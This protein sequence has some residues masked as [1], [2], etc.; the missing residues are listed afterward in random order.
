MEKK[1]DN[2]GKRRAKLFVLRNQAA[3]TNS[4]VGKQYPGTRK[5]DKIRDEIQGMF[6]QLGSL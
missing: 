2:T 1:Y 3:K 4:K 5:R 6:K